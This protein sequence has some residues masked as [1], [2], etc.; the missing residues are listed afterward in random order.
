MVCSC[1]TISRWLVYRSAIQ[2]SAWG[3]EVTLSPR[4]ATTTIG[5]L[6]RRRT[7]RRR[8]EV[9]IVPWVSL[10][11]TNSSSTMWRVSSLVV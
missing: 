4:D 11:P 1:A 6:M 7:I 5:A 3:S 2:Y 8:S 10:L 9:R